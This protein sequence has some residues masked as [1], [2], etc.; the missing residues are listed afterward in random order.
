MKPNEFLEEVTK[1]FPEGKPELEKAKDF[2][3]MVNSV[4][5]ILRQGA[6]QFSDQN[7]LLYEDG[8][9]AHISLLDERIVIDKKHL[10]ASLDDLQFKK[11]YHLEKIQLAMD[12]EVKK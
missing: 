9:M 7:F 6:D 12:L 2:L 11:G 5:V 10:A 3:P 4:N 8:R 1:V